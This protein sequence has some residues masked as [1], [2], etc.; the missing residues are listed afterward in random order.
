MQKLI[1]GIHEFQRSIFRPQRELF[2]KLATGQNPETLFITC[3]DSRINPNLITQTQ[4]GELFIIRNAGNIIPPH[5]LHVG[6]EAATIEYAIA[7]LKVKDIIICGHT[8]C[9]AMK[10]VVH[11][12][13]VNELPRVASWLA[14]AEA[15]RQIIREH[16]RHLEGEARVTATVQENVLVQLEHLRTQPMVAAGIAGGTLRLH[17]W[18][19][20][21]E[22][23]E[24]FA[25]DPEQR[26]FLPVA[27]ARLPAA[28]EPVT[29]FQSI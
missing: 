16:Y 28:P 27:D 17:G 29:H 12:A 8:R 5:S 15:T 24:V 1:Q 11:P 22:T 9:G 10:A 7:A 2:E 25:F 26:Q 13:D 6:G 20:K 18:V 3:S 4:P 23:G 19:Y 21:I 14:H